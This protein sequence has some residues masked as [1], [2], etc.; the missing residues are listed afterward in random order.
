[1]FKKYLSIVI[2]ICF[3]VVNMLPTCVFALEAEDVITPVYYMDFSPDSDGKFYDSPTGTDGRA[4]VARLDNPAGT[5][6]LPNDNG[7]V[8]NKIIS[9]AT[10]GRIYAGQQTANLY[11]AFSKGQAQGDLN[12]GASGSVDD[13]CLKTVDNEWNISSTSPVTVTFPQSYGG[14]NDTVHRYRYEM[15]LKWQ[16]YKTSSGNYISEASG[17][18]ANATIFRFYVGDKEL[19]LKSKAAT[20]TADAR[21]GGALYFEC[22]GLGLNASGQKT[23]AEDI[24]KVTKSAAAFTSAESGKWIH[25]TVDFDFA[26]GT[27]HA[28]L[29]GES[30][31]REISTVITSGQASFANGVSAFR[32]LG[33][34]KGARRIHFID[35]IKLSTIVSQ[36]TD[37]QILENAASE[38]YTFNDIK[39]G[40]TNSSNVTQDLQLPTGKEGVGVTW[41]VA[42]E[43]AAKYINL[44]TGAVSR[45]THVD[46]DITISLTPTY[47]LNGLTRQGTEVS[48]IVI[49]ALDPAD[50]PLDAEY[51]M[52]FSPRSDGNFYDY[53]QNIPGG[54][55]V[56]M[57]D[58]SSDSLIFNGH[59]AVDNSCIALDADD[60]TSKIQPG[61]RTLNDYVVFSKGNTNGD[62]NTGASGDKDDYCLKMIDTSTDSN[63]S[64]KITLPKAYGDP[65]TS[66]DYVKYRFEMDYKWQHYSSMTATSSERPTGTTWLRFYFGDNYINLYSKSGSEQ[67]AAP[68]T[69][70]AG[71]LCFT[72]TG[73]GMG[74]TTNQIV[75]AG[76]TGTVTAPMFGSTASGSWVHITVDFDFEEHTIKAVLEGNGNDDKIIETVIPDGTGAGGASFKELFMKGLTGISI[77]GATGGN[78]R[79]I[80]ADNIKISPM[81]TIKKTPSEKLYDANNP[82]TS[83]EDIKGANS[84]ASAV[85]ENLDLMFKKG[86]ADVSWQVSPT[87]GSKYINVNSGLVTRPAY[88]KGDQSVTLTPTYT[89]AGRKLTGDSIDIVVSA[90]PESALEKMERLITES[91][92]TFADIKGT[93]NSA[94]S[95]SADLSLPSSA[96]G[97]ILVIWSVIP[98]EMSQYADVTTGKIVR[99]KYTD[100]DITLKLVPTYKSGEIEM[101]GELIEITIAKNT[102]DAS[103]YD[104]LDAYAILDSDITNGQPI[105]NVTGNLNLPKQGK[106]YG[107][108]I[109]WTSSSLVVDANTGTVKRPFGAQKTNV[110]LTATVTNGTDT[111]TR[112]FSVTLVDN[113][114]GS[115]NKYPS[116]GGGS[117]GGGVAFAGG[118]TAGDVPVTPVLPD[119]EAVFKDIS[120]VPW[121]EEYIT[122]LFNSGV[123]NGDGSGSFYPERNVTR[124]E[125]VKMLLL[126]FDIELGS[127]AQA[128]FADVAPGSWFAPYVYASY[129][130]GIVNGISATE[131][132]TGKNI[133]RQDLA[134]MLVRCLEH[135]EIALDNSAGNLTFGD[136][137]DISGYATY[138]VKKLKDAGVFSGDVNGNFN[139]ESFATRAEVAKVLGILMPTEIK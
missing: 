113:K 44:S 10:T 46:G 68:D 83:F 106:L 86:D 56:K 117:T 120:S 72:S 84:D 125:F 74:A 9:T 66:G 18:V 101:I 11:A 50:Y 85:T 118:S 91:P 35:N 103:G 20:E 119:K 112:T 13:Y 40:N 32:M 109:V 104:V 23:D 77:H 7:N 133:T 49:K 37:E 4:E 123:I 38:S 99:P 19:N 36:L 136:E 62:V 88:T 122:K 90:L 82:A 1:M 59:T 121:A 94:Q 43:S 105:N 21:G 16:Q 128:D 69:N 47:S 124:E 17:S 61:V 51:Y 26:S 98:A 87:T 64:V 138:A 53:P 89:V 67:T 102:L 76:E 33:S 54:T 15:D 14:T 111:T 81:A 114:Y 139:P 95:V 73:F 65:E 28:K 25:V 31:T 127:D 6:Q 100:A 126:T 57:V 45:P 52:D 34:T 78:R 75:P 70:G 132:G 3:I 60:N 97:D 137:A 41:S 30:E 108:N 58:L 131:F 135:K 12:T 80:W 48:G 92:F 130:L 63:P 107:S 2:T 93:N 134:V 71:A 39:G 116:G 8:D 29:E 27:I 22:S 5:A 129:K 79:V 96:E 55:M 115:G 110:T 24:A 42:P